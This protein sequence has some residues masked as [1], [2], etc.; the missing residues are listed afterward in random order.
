MERIGYSVQKT[1]AGAYICAETCRVDWKES[2]SRGREILYQS[3]R[4]WREVFENKRQTL[5]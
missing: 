5:D 1:E 3:E 2:D 4:K